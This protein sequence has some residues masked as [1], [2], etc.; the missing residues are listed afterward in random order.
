[1]KRRK[2][3]KRRMFWRFVGKAWKLM[4]LAAKYVMYALIGSTVTAAIVP[5]VDMILSLQE[6]RMMLGV[7][8][9]WLAFR[10]FKEDMDMRYDW[11]EAE[12]MQ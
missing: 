9:S 2:G 6:A 5:W 11:E 10:I 12:E 1:M 8:L 4:K 3:R 7:L